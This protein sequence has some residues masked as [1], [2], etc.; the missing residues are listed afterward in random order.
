[1]DS[2]TLTNFRYKT[3]I[4]VFFTM[5][6]W[7]F[8]IN[9]QTPDNYK[10]Q[11]ERLQQ[12]IAKSANDTSKVALYNDLANVHLKYNGEAQ[13]LETAEQGLTLA[14]K[15]D[16]PI[17][18]LKMNLHK[19][20]AIDIMGQADNA[21]SLYNEGLEMALD[22]DEK[23]LVAVYYINIGICHYFIGDLEL[24]LKNYLLAYDMHQY[25]EKD[26]LGRLLNNIAIIYRH[27]KDYERAEE[28]YLKS[29][30][31]K[32]EIQDSLGM[33][34]SLYNLGLVYNEIEGKKHLAISTLK[35]SQRLYDLLGAKYDAATCD[36]A[37]GKVYYHLDSLAMAKE[38]LTNAWNYLEA[39]PGL[40]L[41]DKIS[42]LGLL[43]EVALKEHNYKKAEAHIETAMNL[44][45]TSDQRKD[46]LKFLLDLSIV[47]DQLGKNAEAYSLLKEAYA[48][49]DTFTETVRLQSMEEMQAKFDVKE[50][51]NELVIS[52]LK[53]DKRTRQRNIFLFGASGLAL[54]AMIVFFLL[55]HRIRA[56]K[57][58]AAQNQIL[59][60]QK[61]TELR[62]QNK[63]LSLNSM[64]EGQE[65]ERMRIAKDL[66]DSLGGLLSTVKAHFTTIQNEISQLTKLNITHKTNELID[67]ACVEVRRISHNMIPHALT[68]SGLAVALED[69]ADGL[70]TEGYQVDLDIQNFSSEIEKTKQAMLFR[71]VQE[72]VS[73]IRKH[74]NAKQILIQIIGGNEGMS[75]IIEDDGDGFDFDKAIT[76]GG[77]GLKSINSRVEF[78][79][80]TIDWDTNSGEGTTITINIP[81]V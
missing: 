25:L 46:H 14:R 79:N 21:L 12:L 4:F 61:I 2:K 27:Q 29:Y 80:G 16:F 33:S 52:E 23:N 36:I 77:V 34:A 28:I 22:Q 63:L 59:Q 71:L 41:D 32:G 64:I 20:I 30:E 72:V 37:L 5:H 51:E 6:F 76:S 55:R 58:I 49:N 18:I 24:A 9:A 54:F 1:M 7:P 70:R 50:K 69:M 73:N 31:L 40:H 60:E 47:K 74:A 39:T 42:T 10:Q 78:L 38:K 75:I 8:L 17:G 11:V 66:H 53:L 56:N 65:A 35:R 15:L 26:E 3:I 48:L 57:Q 81:T 13:L 68:L 43:G 67:E 45:T 19:A 62:Q 44:L